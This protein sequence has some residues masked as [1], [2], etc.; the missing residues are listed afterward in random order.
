[1]TGRHRHFFIPGAQKAGSTTLAVL[2][3]QHPQ[4]YM[5]KPIVPEPLFFLSGGGNDYESYV[6]AYF[7][8][9]GSYP[10]WGEKSVSYMDR[11]V[12][13]PRIAS[14]L[15]DARMVVTLRNPIERA[16]SHYRYSRRNKLETLGFAEAIQR[17]PERVVDLAALNVSAQPFA[18]VGRGKYI[19][20]LRRLLGSFP[21]ENL[22]VVLLDDL[23][24]APRRT[25]S[26]IFAFLGVDPRFLPSDA[27]SRLNESEEPIDFEVDRATLRAMKETLRE[28][29][30]ELAA[31]LERDLSLW[32]LD[33]T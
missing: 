31:F 33:V 22:M 14:V 2:L 32:D 27:G 4:I 5:A 23:V 20:A 29:T 3:D 10:V 18:Y 19:H 16:V 1:M 28:P 13:P 25:C 30:A 6:E 8:E 9:A 12:A 24:T 26:A 17:E 7:R 15:P 21:R 11:D